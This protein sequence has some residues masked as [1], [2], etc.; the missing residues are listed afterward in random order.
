MKINENKNGIQKKRTPTVV[1]N[2]KKKSRSMFIH[3]N[4]NESR[5]FERS[6]NTVKNDLFDP[7]IIMFLMVMSIFGIR[8]EIGKKQLMRLYQARVR[9]EIFK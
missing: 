3:S 4:G 7:N 2:T 6:I 8:N 9:F 1:P 5:F